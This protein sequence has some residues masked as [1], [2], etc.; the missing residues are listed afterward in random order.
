[1][2]RKV[3]QQPPEAVDEP[4]DETVDAGWLLRRLVDEATADIA[5]LYDGEG[6]FEAGGRVAG[7]VAAG[8]GAGRGDRGAVR[9]ARQRAGTGG[10]CEEGAAE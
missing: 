8:P 6:R 2:P 1:M 9:G 4:G 5:D 10:V 3:K 7:G